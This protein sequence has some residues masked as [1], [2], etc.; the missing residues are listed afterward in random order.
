MKQ[1][2]LNLIKEKGILLDKD[3][4]NLINEVEDTELAKKFINILEKAT[5]Q[6]MITGTTLNKNIEHVQEVTKDLPG[7]MKVL[8]EKTFYK[9]GLSLEVTKKIQIKNKQNPNLQ[10]KIFYADTKNDKK[11]AVG[12][13]VKHFRARYQQIQNILM[14]RP[15]VQNLVAIN[16]IAPGERQ[17]FNIIGI[18]TEKRKTINDNLI[19][20][21]EDLTGEISA[22]VKKDS[23]C[24]HLAEELL[25]DDIVSVRVSGNKDFLFIHDI[26]FPGAFKEKTLFDQDV[27][28]G[29]ISDIHVGSKN[30]LSSEFTNFI[31]WTNSDHELAKKLKYLFIVGDNVDGVGVFPGQETKLNISNLKEQYISLA[32]YLKQIPK[33]IT[34]F[35]C[36]GQHDATRVPE[37]QPIIDKNYGAP[38][39][40]IENLV[41]VP[42][43]TMIKLLEKEKEFK[44]LMYHGASIHSFIS[45]INELRLMKAHRCPAKAVK[46]MLKRR[47]LAP[48]HSSV[49]Y[50]PNKDCDPLVIDETPDILCT[51]EVHRLDIERHNGVMIITGSCWQSQTDFEEKVGNIPDPC[52]VPIINLKTGELKILDFTLESTPKPVTE[53]A[54]GPTKTPNTQEPAKTTAILQTK[55]PTIENIKK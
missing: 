8:V 52:K 10:Y 20:K 38:L 24:A 55:T 23:E 14:Q 1:E 53:N 5:G 30:H 27:H 54:Q 33:N 39:R 46:H 36:P 41:L 2:I 4:Y 44:V 35:M 3:I 12:D 28:I 49:V 48:T 45:E 43:P 29:F 15:D 40:E 37:P 21:F 47:H 18:V 34:I 42:N 7:E 25:L 32:N 9:L 16:K 13:F 22:L 19:I 6:K 11:I 26:I 17:S 51:G 50:V 31:N